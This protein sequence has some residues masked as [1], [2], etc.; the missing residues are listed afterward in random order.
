MPDKQPKKRLFSRP[1]FLARAKQRPRGVSALDSVRPFRARIG[2]T[3]ALTVVEDLLE[4]SYPFATGL[5]IDGLIAH[6]WRQ[7]IPLIAAWTARGAIGCFRKMY[8]TRVYSDVYNAIVIETITRQRAAGVG[9]SGVAARSAMAREFVTFF[10]RDVPVLVTSIIG[11]LGSA[12]MLLWYDLWIAAAAAAL[13]LP[14]YLINR[15]YSARSYR[16]N[17]ALNNQLEEEVRIIER[18]ELE[19]VRRHFGRLRTFRV[20]LSDA[21]AYN[22][23]SIEILSIFAFIAILAR[24]TFLPT[25]ET[26]DIYAILAYVWRLMENL[27]NVPTLVQQLARLVDIRRRIESGATIESIGAELEKDERE[28]AE[29]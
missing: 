17:Q 13:F 12:A 23:T 7:A 10:E 3:Y 2:L 9:A 25:T 22:W 1:R 27:D 24:A 4:L 5:A 26:G 16:L 8:D 14:V 29:R 15:V 18:A 21:E 6:D 28:G 20:K 11:I 19:E